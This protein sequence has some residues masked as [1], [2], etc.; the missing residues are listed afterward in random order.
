MQR[1]AIRGI[2]KSGIADV[3]MR[4]ENQ[5]NMLDAV[6]FQQLRA[7][8]NQI[9]AN[10]AARVAVLRADGRMFSA[11]LDLK[12]SAGVLLNTDTVGAAAVQPNETTQK[13]LK[14]MGSKD[15]EMPAMRNQHVLQFI[16][17]WQDCVS[18]LEECRVPVIAAIHGQ[19]LGGGVDIVTAAD[20]R[21]CTQDAVFAVLEAR[22]GITADIGTLARLSRI[23]GEG[24]AREFSMTARD[25]SAE[26]AL[27]AGLVNAVYGSKDEMDE[28]VMAMAESIASNSPL[29]VQGTKRVLNHN[30]AD[31]TRRSLEFVRMWNTSMLR[32]DDL[33]AALVAFQK[34]VTP[35]FKNFMLPPRQ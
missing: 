31:S 28:K 25:I 35:D 14:A 20:M 1:V 32:S 17:D 24:R 2:S 13:T 34:K 10:P 27:R 23:V 22:V 21:V 33:V 11:G 16:E 29:A 8:M 12:G 26:E 3:T 18:S 19:C 15:T 30:N 6:Y 7:S 5:L 9:S 4:S